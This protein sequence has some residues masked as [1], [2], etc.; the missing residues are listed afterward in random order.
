MLAQAPPPPAPSTQP[1]TA[2]ATQ[3]LSRLPQIAMDDLL[4]HLEKAT[5]WQSHFSN[6]IELGWDYGEIPKTPIWFNRNTYT[7]LRLG[8]RFAIRGSDLAETGAPRFNYQWVYNGTMLYHVQQSPREPVALDLFTD[9]DELASAAFH[10]TALARDVGTLHGYTISFSERSLVERLR[11]GK[12]ELLGEE[13]I[14]EHCCYVVRSTTQ[15]GTLTVWIDPAQG[16]NAIKRLLVVGENDLLDGEP[17][18]SDKGSDERMLHYTD[19]A[20]INEMERIEARGNVYFVPREVHTDQRT[21]LSS[22]N[23]RLFASRYR[24][25]DYNLDPPA[26]VPEM[27]LPRVPDG[28]PVRFGG[29]STTAFEWRQGE[30]VP[31]NPAAP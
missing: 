29:S 21:A 7:L 26:N 11:A 3:P 4:A 14:S 15:E 16:F 25:S 17:L 28:A 20:E 8:D 10:A 9:P 5:E 6:T 27:F 2:P 1:T 30:I 31:T 12:P 24:H 13:M 18:G 22:G 23:E 19:V